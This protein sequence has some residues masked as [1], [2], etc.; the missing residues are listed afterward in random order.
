MNYSLN[1]ENRQDGRMD[2]CMY[3][4]LLLLRRQN[5][6]Y[7]YYNDD[8]KKTRLGKCG[9]TQSRGKYLSLK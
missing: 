6:Y 2:V 1:L 4:L 3:L 5:N 9:A 7:Y 8:R